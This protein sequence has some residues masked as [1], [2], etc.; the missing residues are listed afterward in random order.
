ML[1]LAMR[2]PPCGDSVMESALAWDGG[3]HPSP[4]ITGRAPI[5]SSVLRPEMTRTILLAVP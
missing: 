3:V 2:C 1:R 4:D 5:S